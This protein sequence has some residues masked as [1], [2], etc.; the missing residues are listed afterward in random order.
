[1][2]AEVEKPSWYDQI[3]RE[4]SKRNEQCKL[5]GIGYVT[6]LEDNPFSYRSFENFQSFHP[7]KNNF[8]RLPY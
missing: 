7:L 4:I 3:L 5:Q 6:K 8:S 1:M 2:T